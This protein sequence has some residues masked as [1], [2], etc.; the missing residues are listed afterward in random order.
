VARLMFF[1]KICFSMASQDFLKYFSSIS[2][3]VFLNLILMTVEAEK[4]LVTTVCAAVL[5]WPRTNSTC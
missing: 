2:Q 4:R 3:V 5:L 1:S